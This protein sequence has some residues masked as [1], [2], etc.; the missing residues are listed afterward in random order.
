MTRSVHDAT[1]AVNCSILFADIPLLER[2]A[3]ARAAGFDAVEFRWP[4]AQPV[5]PESEVDAFVEAIRAAEVSLASFGFDHGDLDAGDRGLFASESRSER[6][7]R[8]MDV[9]VQIGA[10]TGCSTFV[11]LL[12]VPD[13]PDKS[14]ADVASRHFAE[15]GRAVAQVG[16]KIAIEAVSGTPR[17]AIQTIEHAVAF[18]DGVR[19]STGVTNLGVLADLFH[20]SATEHDVAAAIR[21]HAAYI[22]HVQVA[23][24]PGRGVPGSGH[25]PL[26]DLLVLLWNLGYGGSIGL[27]FTPSDYGTVSDLAQFDR[28]L[29][30][31]RRA[32]LRHP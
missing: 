9:V 27:E 29:A 4:F 6:L 31:L 30:N 23:D 8:N 7:R 2:P 16:G 25:Q 15:A 17:Y 21:T 10:R 5:P 22:C 18:I 32:G 1:F 24:R 28:W 14:A 20:L 13:S 12:G 11:G 26:G 19:E 3:A